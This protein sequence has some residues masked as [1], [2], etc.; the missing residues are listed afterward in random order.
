MKAHNTVF[1]LLGGHLHPVGSGALPADCFG[2]ETRR[3]RKA[4][5][6]TEKGFD[7]SQGSY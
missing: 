5:R 1:R 7:S 6:V 3:D 4:D 2:T